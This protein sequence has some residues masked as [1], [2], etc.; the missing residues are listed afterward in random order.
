MRSI[1]NVV[2]LISREAGIKLGKPSRAEFAERG[3]ELSDGDSQMVPLVEPLLA[4]LATMLREFT[5]KALSNSYDAAANNRV[6]ISMA[7]TNFLSQ[8]V[9]NPNQQNLL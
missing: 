9:K 4:I 2:R 1:E 3:R 8:R 6:S 7:K 5:E